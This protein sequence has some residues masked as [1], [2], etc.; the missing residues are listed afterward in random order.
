MFSVHEQ[1]PGRLPFRFLARF[2]V[3]LRN[4]VRMQH[5]DQRNWMKADDLEIP[6]VLNS[7]KFLLDQ[8]K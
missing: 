3:S 4:V 8:E 2:L 7:E 5:R 1:E 6:L